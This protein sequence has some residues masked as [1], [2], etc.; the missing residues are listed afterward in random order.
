MTK[1]MEIGKKYRSTYNN[2]V[3]CV[4]FDEE[5]NHCV[6]RYTKVR[7]KSTPCS[8][9]INHIIINGQI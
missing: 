9:S 6:V 8:F 2:E 4:G 1:R 3:V 5:K 7:N